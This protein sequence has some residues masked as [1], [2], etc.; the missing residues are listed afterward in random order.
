[1]DPWV[2]LIITKASPAPS[3]GSSIATPPTDDAAEVGLAHLPFQDAG[4]IRRNEG[5]STADDTVKVGLPWLRFQG[6]WPICRCNVSKATGD[7]IEVRV[8]WLC[9]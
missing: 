1:M 6:A 2:G 8:L 4:P 9:F 7:N 5:L 3:T